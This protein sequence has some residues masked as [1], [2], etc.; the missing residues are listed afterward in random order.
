MPG[1]YDNRS[2]EPEP[3]GTRAEPG[4]QVESRGDLPVAGE[5]VFDDKG[6]VKPERL[7]LDIVFDKITKSFAAV[8]FGAAAPCRGAAEKAELHCSNILPAINSLSRLSRA[9]ISPNPYLDCGNAAAA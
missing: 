3:A 4:Q 9:T 5:M 8:E 7:G 1:E 6:A 2:S